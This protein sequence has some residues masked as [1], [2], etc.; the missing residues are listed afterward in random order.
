MHNP[1]SQTYLLSCT[2]S[3]SCQSS[4][5]GLSSEISDLLLI[6]ERVLQLKQISNVNSTLGHYQKATQIKSDINSFRKICRDYTEKVLINWNFLALGISI[7]LLFG[8]FLVIAYHINLRSSLKSV[9][10]FVTFRIFYKGSA[11]PNPSL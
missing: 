9:V 11:K 4:N 6:Q 7:N 2:C 5:L 1:D 10:M 8:I 3:T